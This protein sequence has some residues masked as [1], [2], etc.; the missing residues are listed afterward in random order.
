MR[1]DSLA[2]WPHGGDVDVEGDDVRWRRQGLL[3]PW[4]VETTLARGR[5]LAALVTRRGGWRGRY[6][7]GMV[8]K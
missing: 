2:G 5:E 6:F 4:S 1:P 8:Q 7:F 3:W